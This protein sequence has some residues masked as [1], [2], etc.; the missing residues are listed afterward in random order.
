MSKC[1][2]VLA[3][4][5]GGWGGGRAGVGGPAAPPEGS[6]E[7]ERSGV[8]ELGTGEGKMAEEER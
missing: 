6:G 2:F 5:W 4:C 8:G 1:L 3:A 7:S